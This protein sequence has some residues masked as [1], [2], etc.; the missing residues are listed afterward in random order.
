MLSLML[1]TGIVSRIGSG[2]ISDRIGGLRTLLL[3]S[4]LQA[5]AIVAFLGADTLTLLYVVS[6][7][8]GLSQGGIVPSYTIIIRTFFPAHEAGRR[9]G[10][11]ML[12]TFAGMALGGLDGGRALRPHGLVYRVLHQPRSPSTC[13]T[14][15]SWSTSRA[16]GRCWLPRTLFAHGSRPSAGASASRGHARRGARW[17]LHSRRAAVAGCRASV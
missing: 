11:A 15:R 12:F 14:P 3:G 16:A 17:A 2:F 5:L 13:S 4:V 1:G 7:I 8:F 10:W 9:V 6:A